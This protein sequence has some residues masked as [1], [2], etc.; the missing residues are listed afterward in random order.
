MRTAKI[1]A[2]SNVIRML[3]ALLT[4]TRLSAVWFGEFSDEKIVIV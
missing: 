1:P 3:P 2:A 4:L